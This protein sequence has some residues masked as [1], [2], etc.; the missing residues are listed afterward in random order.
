MSDKPVVQTK[1][2]KRFVDNGDGT[3]SDSEMKLMW[4]QTDAFQD[5]SKFMNWYDCR[6][7]IIRINDQRFAG[8]RDWRFPTLEEAQS[9][10]DPSSHIRDMDRFE[11]FIDSSFSPGGGYSTWTDEERAYG[12]AV[13]YFFRYGYE[14]LAHKDGIS[15]DTVRPVRPIN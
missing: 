11:I 15:K 9:L 5:N 6:D 7:Y 12:T 1:E 3:V 4:K 10:Y 2:K 8:Y 14:D 13:V